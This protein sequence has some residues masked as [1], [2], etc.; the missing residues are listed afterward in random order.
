MKNK[1]KLQRSK[2][3]TNLKTNGRETVNNNGTNG[4]VT[5][6][7]SGSGRSVSEGEGDGHSKH[8]ETD[9][10]SRA[11]CRRQI[12]EDDCDNLLPGDEMSRLGV[13]RPKSWSPDHTT[14]NTL[15]PVSPISG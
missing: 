15:F 4:N 9:V 3:E 7:G 5:T 12:N 8:L 2:S 11:R 13:G 14:A 1:E 10:S 6:E